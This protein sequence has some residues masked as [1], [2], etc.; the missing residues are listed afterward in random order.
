MPLSNSPPPHPRVGE[1]SREAGREMKLLHFIYGQPNLDDIRG[2][3]QKVLDLMNEFEKD[4]DMMTVGEPKGKIVTDLI[5]EIKP[6][7]MIELGC[8]VGY[9]AILFG[10]AVRRNGGQRYL[11]LELNPEWA[12][13]A[14]MLI[15]LAGLRDFVRVIVG[16]SDVSLD[17]LY[18]SGDVTKIELIFIDHYKPAYTTDLKLCEHLGMIVPGS[19]L[20]ADNV[21]HPGNPPYL[22]YVRSS[23]EQKREA[24]KQ[25]PTKGYNTE[26]IRER[27]VNSF[28]PEGDTPAFEVIGNPNLQYE[29]VLRQPEGQKDAIE[30]TRC[31]GVEEA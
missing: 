26:G 9:S 23:V 8:Y 16:R 3:P 19:V 14:N 15:E 13:I 25:G 1:R 11:S 30:V 18:R 27:A 17:K 22:E 2:H 21:I 7:T 5:D 28:M 20:A 24:A 4:Y 10:E 6:K 12:A 29:S 31:V